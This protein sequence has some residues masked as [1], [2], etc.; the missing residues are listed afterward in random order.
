M[1]LLAAGFF[2][3]TGPGE[4]FVNNLGTIIDTFYIPDQL[5]STGNPT[6]SA[7]HVSIVAL[8]STVARIITGTLSDLLAPTIPPHQHR[9]GPNS[10]ANSLAS[11]GTLPQKRVQ[12]S[13]VVFVVIFCLICSIGQVVL[14]SG[15]VQ[16]HAERFWMVSAS[17]GAG[18]GAIFSLTPIIVSV[19]W[20]V[21]NF[22]TNWGI[23]AMAPAAGAAVWGLIY[24]AV[25]SSAVMRMTEDDSPM[26]PVDD[27]RKCYGS[28]C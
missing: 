25:Y 21:E 15:V 12:L 13:R 2:L 14:A 8:S 22:G 23:V 6:D 16:N 26:D 7:T 5:P 28:R 3:T 1:W 19:V 4:A 9:R 11:V 10:L 24:S 17:I 27:E 18:Y 20:G